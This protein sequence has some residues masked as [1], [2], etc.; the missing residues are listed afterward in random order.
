MNP[1]V[2]LAT[3]LAMGAVRIRGTIAVRAGRC[4][5]MVL[6]TIRASATT[7]RDGRAADAGPCSATGRAPIHATNAT[8]TRDTAAVTAA[9]CCAMGRATILALAIRI[10]AMGAGIAGRCS[11][12][13][14]AT[15]LVRLRDGERRR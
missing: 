10:M 12:M 8:S 15:T 14:L 6:V 4:N 7:T 9:R 11:A 5:A 1:T 3:I 13:G 2:R